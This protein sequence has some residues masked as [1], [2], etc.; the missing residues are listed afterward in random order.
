LPERF[1]F[2][3]ARPWA[4]YDDFATWF[5]AREGDESAVARF[6]EYAAGGG[7]CAETYINLLRR[8]GRT[9]EAVAVAREHFLHEDDRS[10]RCPGLYELANGDPAILAEVAR[11]RGDAVHY[12]AARLRQKE[13]KSRSGG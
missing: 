12:L 9:D 2:A 10:L 11:G 8:L 3:G 7:E 5:A 1:A 13:K 6:R 4:T